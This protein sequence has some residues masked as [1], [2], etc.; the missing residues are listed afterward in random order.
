ME[1]KEKVNYNKVPR[2][3]KSAE[4]VVEKPA[5]EQ[6]VA[7]EPKKFVNAVIY[8]CTNVNYR[9]QPSYDAPVIKVLKAGTAVKF[10]PSTKENGFV[11]TM[12]GTTL[13]WVRY[14][15]VKAVEE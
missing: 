3:K 13:G 6:P 2:K 9:E 14:E 7:E 5:V 12:L 1:E 4:A 10:E 8:N 15:Y 11:K